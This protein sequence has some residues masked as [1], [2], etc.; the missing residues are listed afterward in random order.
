MLLLSKGEE[1]TGGREREYILANTFEAVLGSLYLEKGIDFCRA[2][3]NRELLH[4]IDEIIENKAYKDDK[5]KFQ[6]KAQEIKGV[7]PEYKLIDSWGPDHEK[8]FKIGVYLDEDL[9]GEGEGSSKQKAEQEAAKSA[10]DK[11]NSQRD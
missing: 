7:T 9:W 2:F 1:A 4:K 10:L 5:S 11:L 6:E 8:N 3:V